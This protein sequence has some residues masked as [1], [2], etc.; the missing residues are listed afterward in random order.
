MRTGAHV[1]ALRIRASRWLMCPLSIDPLNE[2]S[3]TIPRDRG[4]RP[5]WRGAALE[6]RRA[7]S[8]SSILL[9][10]VVALAFMFA[11][12]AGALVRGAL[13]GVFHFQ[14]CCPPDFHSAYLTVISYV[15]FTH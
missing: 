15:L 10:I 13:S 9:R 12:P 11:T 3:V 4:I 6:C 2:A 8:F 5:P 7:A 1:S 14:V